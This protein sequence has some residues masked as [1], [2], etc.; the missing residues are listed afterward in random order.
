M[1][2]QNGQSNP[3]KVKHS[4]GAGCKFRGLAHSHHGRKQDSR[5][6][7]ESSTLGLAH[8]REREPHLNL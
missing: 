4:I 8:S 2:R 3:Y 7:A 1:K 5:E 6:V